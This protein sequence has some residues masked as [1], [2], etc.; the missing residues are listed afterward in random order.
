MI[1]K[2]KS[3]CIADWMFG[4]RLVPRPPFDPW[5]AGRKATARELSQLPEYLID[6]VAPLRPRPDRDN[7]KI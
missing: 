1:W 6:D 5:S 3:R 2:T 7:H 4:L